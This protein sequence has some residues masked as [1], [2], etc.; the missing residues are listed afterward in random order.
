[1]S[2]RGEMWGCFGDD[3]GDGFGVEVDSGSIRGRFRVDSG[4][5]CGCF[6]I[7][8]RTVWLRFEVAARGGS[9]LPLRA[10][11]AACRQGERERE[12]RCE[13][14][15]RSTTAPSPTPRCLARSVA[16]LA[17]GRRCP[18]TSGTRTGRRSRGSRSTRPTRP[19]HGA[20]GPPP[21]W[22]RK[23]ARA[24]P[25]RGSREGG[26]VSDCVCVCVAV[27]ALRR[28]SCVQMLQRQAMPALSLEVLGP[29]S[30]TN[31]R[32]HSLYPTSTT[33]SVHSLA[34]EP[35]GRLRYLTLWPDAGRCWP[36]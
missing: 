35:N 13:S 11:R 31:W 18:C 28:S 16:T 12:R 29:K 6:G 4:S 33:N 10:T 20:P 17:A 9:E 30:T 21:G 32:V 23:R 2:V 15:C 5:V 8:L 1:M 36:N 34:P 3:L 7:D 24:G 14:T 25:R 27:L 22:A 26:S 19:L